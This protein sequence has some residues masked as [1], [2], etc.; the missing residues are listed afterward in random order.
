MGNAGSHMI[1]FSS[2]LAISHQFSPIL[3]AAGPTLKAGELSWTKNCI[4]L[5]NLLFTYSGGTALAIAGQRL[6][7]DTNI[8]LVPSYHCPAAIEPFIWLGY[9]C[10]FYR[11]NANLTPDLGHVNQLISQHQVSHCLIINYFGVSPFPQ[12]ML[13]R[14]KEKKIYIIYDCAHAMFDVLTPTTQAPKPD[15]IIC[16]VNKLLPSID[17]GILL[18]KDSAPPKLTKVSWW[19][20]LKAISYSIGLTQVINKLRPKLAQPDKQL[21]ANATKPPKYRYFKSDKLGRCCFEH[22]RRLV[23]HCNLN[24]I[25]QRRRANYLYLANLLSIKDQQAGQV[26]FNELSEN[27]VPYVLPFLLNDSKHFN[28]L[29]QAGI[30]SLRWEEIAISDCQI[31]QDYRHCLVQLPCH[32][33]LTQRDLQAIAQ[34]IKEI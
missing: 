12:L 32:H 11:V 10:I 13:D 16:S 17:G 33:Q 1:E 4:D 21:T 14:L 5:S 8:I 31:S 9:Q 28:R 25:K 29:R 7:N 15:A 6:K 34:T 22:T 20:E 18:L 3:Y 27:M 2:S 19:P 23:A 30:Q 26:L 24:Q